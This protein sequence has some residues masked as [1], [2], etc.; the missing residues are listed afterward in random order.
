MH[1]CGEQAKFPKRFRHESLKEAPWATWSVETTCF[2]G[3]G[4]YDAN[5]QHRVITVFFVSWA[6]SPNRRNTFL[7]SVDGEPLSERA[8]SLVC[9]RSDKRKPQGSVA[10]LTRCCFEFRACSRIK[11]S[12][13]LFQHVSTCF[14]MFQHVSKFLFPV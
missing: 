4:V 10:W 1:A 12:M 7:D 3:N 13:G 11:V 14:N 9:W 6:C 8:T 5:T 2:S